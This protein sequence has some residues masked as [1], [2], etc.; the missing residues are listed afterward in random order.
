MLRSLRRGFYGGFPYSKSGGAM[1]AVLIIRIVAFWGLN[2]VPPIL[3]K[4]QSW[5][6]SASPPLVLF[7]D[8][9]R[10]CLEVRLHANCLLGLALL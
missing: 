6:H 8:Q 4:Y 3:G 2:W 10:G 5:I 9:V 1:L 7:L